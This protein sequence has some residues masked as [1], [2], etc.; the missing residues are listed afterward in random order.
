MV[1]LRYVILFVSDLDRSIRF[2]R[3][4]L[5][6][7]VRSEGRDQIEFETG[8]LGLTL[9]QARTDASPHHSPTRAGSVRLGLHLEDVG[10]VHA[11]LTEAGCLCLSPPEQRGGVIMAL[12]EDPDGHHLSLASDVED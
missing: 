12:Y 8:N 5:G 3:D 6:L 9:H 4:V 2:Y 7:A 10:R 11:R 1:E